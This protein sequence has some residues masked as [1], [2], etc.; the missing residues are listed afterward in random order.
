[1]T[2][3][4][5]TTFRLTAVTPVHVGSGETAKSSEYI[6]DGIHRKVYFL[7]EG[8][9]IAYLSEKGLLDDF[10]RQLVQ[11]VAGGR[12]FSIYRYLENKAPMGQIESLLRDMERKGIVY[13]GESVD[14]INPRSGRKGSVNDVKLFA[15]EAGVP[16]IPGSTLKG[17]FRTA[18]LA[19]V[20][21]Q[22]R[23]RYRSLWE[24]LAR[25]KKKY[26]FEN[27]G[28]E[29]EDKLAYAPQSSSNGRVTALDSYFRGLSVSDAAIEKEWTMGIVQKVDWGEKSAE[30]GERPERAK[31]LPIY[32]EALLPGA[33]LTFTVSVDTERMAPLGIT[34]FSELLKVLR[35]FV[36]SQY[37]I[38]EYVFQGPQ[39]EA[40]R[41]TDLLL[42]GGT[43]FISKTLVYSLA[44]EIADGIDVV[45]TILQDQFRKHGHENDRDVSP[46]TLKLTRWDGKLQMMGLCRLEE[47]GS[48]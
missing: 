26:G 17:A 27:I 28:T 11:G 38:L 29:L 2:N 7:D 40:L 15:R 24:R 1:M 48:C 20:L 22:K 18:I 34:S 4:I 32:R 8:R 6:Y 45:S 23:D 39:V 16:Y 41:K 14:V 3:I 47:I 21:D 10:S 33:T 35:N 42:G 12:G 31:N 30:K 43:G 44:P 46:H 13:P 19:G 36:D 5:H 37:N 25:E 9:W